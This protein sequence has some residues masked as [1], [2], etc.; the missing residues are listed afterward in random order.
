[1]RYNNLVEALENNEN[2]HKDVVEVYG[3]ATTSWGQA[4]FTD[5]AFDNEDEAFEYFKENY[6]NTGNDKYMK[7][8]KMTY[9][10]FGGIDIGWENGSICYRDDVQYR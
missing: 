2:Y 7:V 10:K 9:N 3:I 4:Y 1:M 8:R 5:I 6:V